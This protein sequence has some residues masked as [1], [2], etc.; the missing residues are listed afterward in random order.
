MRDAVR[1][2]IDT[3]DGT[4]S[5]STVAAYRRDLEAYATHCR[6]TGARTVGAVTRQTAAA[7]IDDLQAAGRRPATVARHLSALRRFH[8]YL[9]TNGAARIDPT[10][11]LAKP[12]V[13]R[14]DPDPLS[15]D[16]AQRL[17]SAVGG[18]DP[19][20]MRDRAML[21]VLYAAGLRVSELTAL[22]AGDLLLDHDLVRVRGR[23]ARE[24]MV[25]LGRAAVDG[26]RRYARFGRPSLLGVASAEEAP[27]GLF[28]VTGQ[29]RALSR[30]SVWKTIRTAAATAGIDRAVSPQTLRHT[31]AAHL[32]DGGFD[33]R[34]VQHL[35]G[36]ADISTTAIYHRDD[37]ERL[38]QMHRAFH[39]RA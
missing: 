26:C 29:G 34:D 12:R 18:E 32:L 22:R 17:V 3:I 36:H 15:I 20:S 23:G 38:Q 4:L 5:A 10:V 1:A 35:L 30:M 25:P 27:E 21:E 9:C 8:D 39:P 7:H 2:F 6:D 14:R 33:L 24:R 37:D 19:L 28:F 16:E 31:F 13:E 11:D